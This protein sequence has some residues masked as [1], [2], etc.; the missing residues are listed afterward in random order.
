MAE[1]PSQGLPYWPE[2]GLLLNN[3]T[4]TDILADMCHMAR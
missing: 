3:S 1:S 2:Y 4:L